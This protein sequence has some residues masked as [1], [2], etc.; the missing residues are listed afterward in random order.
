VVTNTQQFTFRTPLRD[1]ISSIT[2]S[3]FNFKNVLLVQL[4]VLNSAKIDNYN[5]LLTKTE[6]KVHLY[7]FPDTI[8]PALRHVR[9][10][11]MTKNGKTNRFVLIGESFSKKSKNIARGKN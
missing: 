9:F 10:R 1:F 8:E 5:N 6:I 7:N 3:T 2:L 4:P 11:R